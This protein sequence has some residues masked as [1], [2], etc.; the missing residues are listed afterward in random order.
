MAGAGS[1]LV[2]LTRRSARPASTP[3][4]PGTRVSQRAAR[5]APSS[6]SAGVLPGA[7]IGAPRAAR[8]ADVSVVCA[9]AGAS[10]SVAGL[11]KR[12]AGVVAV[13]R[14]SFEVAPGTDAAT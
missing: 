2:V 8:S 10:L 12:Y 7:S 13:D 4:T 5:G 11:T 6:A 14:V 1:W 3:P 9:L